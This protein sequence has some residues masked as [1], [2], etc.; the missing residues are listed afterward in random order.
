MLKNN[1]RGINKKD[2][3]IDKNIY[4]LFSLIKI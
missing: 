1:E 2:Q 3:K 4:L